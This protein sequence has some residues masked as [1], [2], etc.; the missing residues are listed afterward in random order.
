MA[1]FGTK[2]TLVCELHGFWA[3]AEKEENPRNQSS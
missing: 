1:T 2:D 3:K